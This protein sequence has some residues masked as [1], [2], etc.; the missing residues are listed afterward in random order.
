MDVLVTAARAG[1]GEPDGCLP[2]QVVFGGND[3]DRSFN[4]VHVLDTSATPW[5]WE[6]PCCVGDVP[7]PRTGHL[8][9]R[10]GTT[11]L[12]IQGGWDPQV[13]EEEDQAGSASGG[14]G[15]LRAF[16]DAFLLDTGA[17]F[18]SRPSHAV[19]LALRTRTQ[20]DAP[21]RAAAVTDRR[22]L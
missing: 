20:R 13:E 17:C 15:G 10:V 14:G 21:P 1:G 16:A 12:L 7:A 22:V 19:C 5:R 3:E 9:C 11:T 2:R 6:Q 4:D 8:A 18:Y